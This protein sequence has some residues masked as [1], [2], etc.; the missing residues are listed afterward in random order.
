M[1]AYF[2][3]TRLG[4]LDD[5]LRQFYQSKYDQGLNASN[6]TGGSGTSLPPGGA[7]NTVL[8][9]NSPTD[10]DV[11]WKAVTGIP[12][13]GGS[14]GYVL[15]KQSTADYDF[16]WQAP[17][18]PINQSISARTAT[19]ANIT[20]SGTFTVDGVPL[21]LGNRVLVKDQTD[22]TQNGLYTVASG[23]WTRTNDQLLGSIIS[24]QEGTINGDVIFMC[25]TNATI[26]LGVTSIV[27]SRVAASGLRDL[28]DGTWT[29]TDASTTDTIR[30]Q[31]RPQIGF[32]SCI[33]SSNA[34]LM[35]ADL[36]TTFALPAAT[37]NNGT[38]GVGASLTATTNGALSV[39]AKSPVAGDMILV[40]NQ[41]N[42]FENGVYTVNAP[43][44]ASN[45]FILVRHVNLDSGDK[46]ARNVLIYVSDGNVFQGSLFRVA[47]VGTTTTIATGTTNIIFKTI[48]H[49][50]AAPGDVCWN[51]ERNIRRFAEDFELFATAV[52]TNATLLSGIVTPM[53]AY[54]TGAGSQVTQTG[55]ADLLP[56]VAQI[57]TGTTATGYG[58]I[59]FGNL[60]SIITAGRAFRFGCK[61]KITT[62]TVPASQAFTTRYGFMDNVG[63]N[64][65][66]PPTAGIYFEANADGSNWKCICNH[67]STPTV[68]DTG[69]A[70]IT[71]SQPFA[72]YCDDSGVA[73]FYLGT[74]APWSISTNWP[75]GS[76]SLG[77]AAQITKTVG[78]TTRSIKV[79]YMS[80]W[81]P[82]TRGNMNM[83]P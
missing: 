37:Y 16:I 78:T 79:D 64:Q 49:P 35:C 12:P 73:W 28:K 10:Q 53:Y 19:T 50:D 56:G 24:V 38:G 39:D 1:Y 21:V 71:G 60:G 83:L 47:P 54:L 81:I 14:T 46:F 32:D 57:E 69:I 11:S 9:K 29:Q 68:V 6:D 33:V 27:F 75:T 34:I 62:L 76:D 44:D 72:I 55:T 18:T 40:K 5:N 82:E 77:C 70:P 45:P 30:V 41:A 52:T 48:A 42:L 22:Q 51:S 4:T 3:P 25:T 43:G 13:V 23:A 65:G 61:S 7:T 67:A 66:T 8:T 31:L 20:L 2:A 15:T 63:I 59:Q 26:I 58:A 74:N 17:S 80:A 36:A